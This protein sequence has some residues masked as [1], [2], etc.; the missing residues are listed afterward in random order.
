MKYSAPV[1]HT[2]NA[3]KKLWH[4]EYLIHLFSRIK[5]NYV[6]CLLCTNKVHDP[7]CQRRNET[8][9]KK[10]QATH[11]L[12]KQTSQKIWSS[13]INQCSFPLQCRNGA[14]WRHDR[15]FSHLKRKMKNRYA[16]THTAYFVTLRKPIHMQSES[17]CL[18]RCINATA[19]RDKLLS[20]HVSYSPGIW[21]MQCI[22]LKGTIRKYK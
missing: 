20:C 22:A 11:N 2:E 1:I 19:Q 14:C 4:S 10:I 3:A 5:P 13:T 7:R 21:A 6:K 16:T 9:G 12:C 15:R 17:V 8:R 18:W